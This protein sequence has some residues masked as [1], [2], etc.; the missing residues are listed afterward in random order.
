MTINQGYCY[1]HVVQSDSTRQ[2]LA[3]YLATHFSHSSESQ[4]DERLRNGEIVL[5][6]K[7]ASGS[8]ELKAGQV[9]LWNRPG[10]LE[11][12][13]PQSYSVIFLDEHMLA[14]SKPSGLP[15]IPGGGYFE[16]TLVGKVRLNFPEARP[17]HRLGRATSG[18]VLFAFS[19]RIASHLTRNWHQVQKQ[20]QALALGRALQDAYDIC[21]PIGKCNHPRLGRVYAANSEG[22]PSRSIARVVERRES[23]TLFE[24]DLLTG[25]PHQIRIHLAFI[26]YPLVGDPLY[27]F[28][29]VPKSE[30]PGLPG[31][32]GY[33]L[34]AKRLV[35]EHPETHL[36]LTLES[37]IPAILQQEIAS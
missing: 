15:T 22:K 16:N 29:G 26:G 11:Q 30:N 31:D 4:W 13:A 12:D 33:H 27:T 6:N 35:L 34:H 14:V 10:W 24:V 19:P 17:V 28:G 7:V 23:T 25:R 37:P 20:Y 8:E 1:R 36:V 32:L 18:I 9:L 5:G 2:S 21:S 3:S